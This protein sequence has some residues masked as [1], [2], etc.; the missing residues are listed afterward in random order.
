MELDVNH[1]VLSLVQHGVDHASDAL[2]RHYRQGLAYQGSCQ[3]G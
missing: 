1:V 2:G 3:I